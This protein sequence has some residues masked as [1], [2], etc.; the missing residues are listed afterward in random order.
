MNIIK[1]NPNTSLN[2]FFD[3]LF[4]HSLSDFVGSDFTFSQ[5]SVNIIDNEDAFSLEL[6]TPGLSKSDISIELNKNQLIISAKKEAEE[7]SDEVQTRREY[8]YSSFTRNFHLPVTVESENIEA[9]YKN[10]VLLVTLP[11]KEEAK[12]KDPLSIKIK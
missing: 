3:N 10:G 2:S 5:P 11:K 4:N 1:N 7:K 6:A 8:N 9:S 12:A